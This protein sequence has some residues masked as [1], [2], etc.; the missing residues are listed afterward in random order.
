MALNALEKG[1][2]VV[3]YNRSP[4]NTR[5]L[6]KEGLDPAFSLGELGRKLDPPRLILIYVPHGQPTHET[7]TELKAL[8]LPSDVVA[9]GGNSHWKDSARHYDDLAASGIAFLD[10]GT[11]GG[12][13]GARRGA[14]FMIG[15]DKEAFAKAELLLRD[16]AVPEG[17]VH[18]G[19]AG[20]VIS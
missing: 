13:E 5:A 7:V 20:P 8:L 4:E 10:V 3:G 12:V 9:D 18:A 1:H 14:C 2:H 15:G 16:L 6:A 17:V 19:R 11:S